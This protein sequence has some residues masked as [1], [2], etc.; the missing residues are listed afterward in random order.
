MDA[1]DIKRTIRE[2]YAKLYANKLANLE[3]MGKC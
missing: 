1:W 2:H 3:N